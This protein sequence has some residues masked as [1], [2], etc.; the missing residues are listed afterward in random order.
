[1]VDN[2]PGAGNNI[3]TEVVAN[4]AADGYTLL[5]VNPANTINATLYRKL[6]FKFLRDICS[7]R[8]D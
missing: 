5:L 2:R 7:G 4:A 3:G 6:P 8:R 1:M